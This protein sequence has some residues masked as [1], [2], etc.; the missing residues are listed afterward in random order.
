M[1]STTS[2][3]FSQLHTLE[4]GTSSR[5]R[6]L[7]RV[8]LHSYRSRRQTRIRFKWFPILYNSEE[9][10]LTANLHVFVEVQS[11]GHPQQA[12]KFCFVNRSLFRRVPRMYT[13]TYTVTSWNA[14]LTNRLTF[15][16]MFTR[17]VALRFMFIGFVLEIPWVQI[18]DLGWPT[19][20]QICKI[21]YETKKLKEKGLQLWGWS[22]EYQ[23]S[24]VFSIRTWYNNLKTLSRWYPAKAT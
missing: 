17:N 16:S 12:F 22:G 18:S 11:K 3:K 4:L 7:S 24:C 2:R 20:S 1:N 8:E 19:Q 13:S 14:S 10:F 5:V 21:Y 23:A 9:E 15:T 6:V